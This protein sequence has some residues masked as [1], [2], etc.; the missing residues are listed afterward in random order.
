MKRSATHSDS[1]S[2]VRL[3]QGTLHLPWVTHPLCVMS[4]VQ[5]RRSESPSSSEDEDNYVPY[6]PVRE[7]K[8]QEVS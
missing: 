6:V 5:R 4:F 2:K 7:R 3:E 1:S 8:K